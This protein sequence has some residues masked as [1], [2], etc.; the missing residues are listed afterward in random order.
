MQKKTYTAIISYIDDCCNKP[1]LR[2]EH[3]AAASSRDAL[4]VAKRRSRRLRTGDI[5]IVRG[6]ATVTGIYAPRPDNKPAHFADEEAVW[7]EEETSN[8]WNFALEGVQ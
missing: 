2:I 3:I 7:T 5:Q 6:P 1:H 4:I 8:R